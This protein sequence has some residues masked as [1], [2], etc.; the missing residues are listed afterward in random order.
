MDQGKHVA[1]IGAGIVGVSTAIWLLRAGHRVTLIDR[2]GPGEGTSHGNGG[3]LASCAMVPVTG[4]GLLRRAPGMLLDSEQPLF[5]RWSY[6]AK[7]APWLV[8]YLRHANAQDTR[9]IAAAMAPI[10][11]DSLADHQAL[12]AGT[13]AEHWIVPSDYLYI[14]KDRAQFQGDAFG[15]DIRRAHGFEWDELEGAALRAYDP[16]FADELG[17][18]VKMGNHGRIADPGRY[19][20]DLAA[21]AVAQ[22]AKLVM[23]DVSDLVRE[24]GRVTGLRAGGETI[25]CD[26]A[27]IATG[28]WS[29]ALAGK[30]GIDVPLES[31]RGYHIELWEPSV[32]PRAPVMIAS[33]KFVATP[34][35]GRIRLAGV[36]E[37]GGLEAPASR[38]PFDL[39]LRHAKKA[40]PGLTWQRAVEWM[41]H[42]PA[43]SDSIPLIG[44]VPGTTGAY[45][46]FGH[47]HVGLTG[48]PKTGRLLA[49][50]IGGHRPN[51]DMTPYAPARFAR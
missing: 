34:M 40:M 28:V 43:P 14:Y 45:L 27:V 33:G 37:F 13:G 7:L 42:R 11:G 48:G 44:E 39:L 17:F 21:H 29:K 51:V 23:A 12:A 36:V 6:L 22:G 32:M 46:G 15:W 2:A 49:Q 1:I 26:A 18:A 8:K 9:R 47:H 30:L 4:P 5:L 35:Q 50:V 10:V 31:E 20:K 19:V 24:G 41:G 16:M 3:V 38:P 25:A